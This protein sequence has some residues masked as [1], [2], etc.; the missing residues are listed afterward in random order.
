M[1]KNEKKSESSPSLV[2]RVKASYD[3]A[4][5]EV[6]HRL[7]LISEKQN[8]LRGLVNKSKGRNQEYYTSELRI[9]A[10]MWLMFNE[11]LEAR[12]RDYFLALKLEE[13]ANK[14]DRKP[15]SPFVKE[16]LE[17][18]VGELVDDRFTKRIGQLF[19]DKGHDAFYDRGTKPPRNN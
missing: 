15:E 6:E 18:Y 2:E 12:K 16:E 9:H 3:E 14:I 17:K 7:P 19:D 4:I 5:A 11:I 8:K 13:L 1:N 10:I